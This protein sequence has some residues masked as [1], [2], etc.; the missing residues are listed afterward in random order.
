MR[1]LSKLIEGKDI[2]L[3]SENDRFYAVVDGVTCKGSPSKDGAINNARK[4]IKRAKA[5]R[6]IETR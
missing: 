1:T 5:L 4:Q 2:G 3:F 6:K